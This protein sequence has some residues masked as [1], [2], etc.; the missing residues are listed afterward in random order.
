MRVFYPV[1]NVLARIGGLPRGPERIH[2]PVRFVVG[3]ERPFL[4]AIE[5]FRQSFL[6]N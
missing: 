6:S 3:G 4:G 1:S 5:S 2:V